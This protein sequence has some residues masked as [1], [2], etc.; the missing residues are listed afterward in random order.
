MGWY[1]R[2]P[3]ADD[4]HFP[5]C[6]SCSLLGLI[7]PNSWFVWSD[8]FHMNLFFRQLH[9]LPEQTPTTVKKVQKEKNKHS[10]LNASS[11]CM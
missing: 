1:W 3:Q 11:R 10:L 4:Q 8:L 6:Y 5:I 9:A 7:N 2:A